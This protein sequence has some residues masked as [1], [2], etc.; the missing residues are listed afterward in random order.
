MFHLQP[1]VEFK[2]VKL[3]GMWFVQVFHRSGTNVSHHFGKS[4]GRLFHF[5]KNRFGGNGDWSFFDDF[6][7]PALN[8]TVASEE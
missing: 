7:M 5:R 8:G 4:N 3:L 2:K 1:R 6:L